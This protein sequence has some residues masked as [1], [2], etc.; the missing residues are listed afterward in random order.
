MAKSVL[1][2]AMNCVMLDMLFVN[3]FTVMAT[4][5]GLGIQ[6]HNVF[7]AHLFFVYFLLRD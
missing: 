4:T 7:M 5:G 6:S 2:I 3:A 1:T